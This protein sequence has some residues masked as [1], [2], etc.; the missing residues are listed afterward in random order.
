M[1]TQYLVLGLGLTGRSCARYL[2]KQGL[3]FSLW[4]SRENP[5]DKVQIDKDFASV[6][7][8]YGSLPDSVEKSADV[9][10]VSPG[11]PLTTPLIARALDQGKSV[12]GDIELFA[13][14]N[15]KPVIG[16]TGSDGKST[17]VTLVGEMAK[18]CGLKAAVIGNIGKPVLDYLDEDYDLAV[19]ELSSFQLAS[20]HSLQ[21]EVACILN[22][23]PDHLD[24]HG[25]MDHY[26]QSKQRI[27]KHAK[28]TVCNK[29]DPATWPAKGQ[30]LSFPMNPSEDPLYEQFNFK[31]LLIQA[32]HYQSNLLAALYI[33]R[34]MG[35]DLERCFNT[36]LQ[37]KG[38]PHRLQLIPTQDG[39]LWFNDSK[40]TNEHAAIAA[41]EN[42]GKTISGKSVLIMGGQPK[43][44]DFSS[45]RGPVGTYAKHVLLIGEAKE[46]LMKTLQDLVPCEYC[47]DLPAAVSRAKQLAEPGDAVILAP[48][49]TSWDMFKDYAE[50]GDLFIQSVLGLGTAEKSRES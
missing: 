23:S 48:A 8:Y 6:P 5:P 19:M 18:A 33:A 41:I 50:R 14:A 9:F 16:I 32:K 13:Q 44:D 31:A 37:F 26:V 3:S 27:Y 30:D 2:Q 21:A 11:L 25:T 1:T 24:W 34:A 47:Q 39:I 45:L 20:T 36:A 17:T 29:D 35:W 40:A 4:D 49:C 46:S 7:R 15:T 10:I 38:L 42:V 22:I 12:I 28:R 43:T